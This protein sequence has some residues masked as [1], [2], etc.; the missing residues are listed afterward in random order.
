MYKNIK[1]LMGGGLLSY[2]PS[3]ENPSYNDVDLPIVYEW[4][5]NHYYPEREFS[6]G[7]QKVL[8]DHLLLFQPKAILEIGVQRNPLELSSTGIILKYKNLDAKYIGVDLEDKSFLNDPS[9]NIY[10][11]KTDSADYEAVYDLMQKLNIEE[12]DLIFIDGFHSINRVLKE[13]KYIENLSEFGV[14]IM[15][16]TN[17][18]PGPTTIFD[19]ID[20]N[21]YHKQKFCTDQN[22]NGIAVFYRNSIMK[23]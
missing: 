23:K 21:V 5:G 13:L 17:W 3:F 11:I 7:N 15:H 22:D 14:V 20:N 19:A 8:A 12:F 18:H 9:K 4:F 2:V 1:K 10:T 16:D 6:D